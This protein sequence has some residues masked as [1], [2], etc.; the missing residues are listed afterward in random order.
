MPA[1]S[2]LTHLLIALAAFGLGWLV[3][4]STGSAPSP[5]D[6][7]GASGS[8][9]ASQ[10]ASI[11]TIEDPLERTAA[12]SAFFEN[13]D[14]SAAL[15]LSEMLAER[16]PDLIIDELTE[17]L[18]GAWWARENPV[19]A[20]QNPLDPAWSERHPYMRNVFREWVRTDPAEAALAVLTLGT[21]PRKGRLEASRVVVDEW[22]A[23]DPMPEPEPLIAVIKQLEP[24]ARD[25]A[26]T[27]LLESMIAERGVDRTLDFV[28][29]IPPDS[30]V[31]GSV[32]FEIQA[33]TGV[34]L[35]DHDV[36]RAIAWA[37]EYEDQPNA[38][39]IQKHIAYYWGL[40]QGAPAVEW[41]LDLPESPAKSAVIKRA[42]ISFSRK[43]R[44]EA[45]EWISARPPIPLMR[46]AFTAYL[47]KLAETEP[48][49]ALAHAER[50]EGDDFRHQMRA[51]V[52]EGWMT[53]DPDA[54]RAWLA[55]A[56]LPPELEHKVRKAR[57]GRRQPNS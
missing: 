29:A 4:Q 50:A 30:A 7:T 32:Q 6:Y 27:H 31:N 14:Q 16:D 2:V 43:H 40:K 22:L 38:A 21:G 24:M 12:L 34:V 56:G 13:T 25:G 28:R 1:R 10:L 44:D 5:R 35:L 36:D 8:N 33:R 9:P 26:I 42:W 3:A 19:A 41:A 49:K 51:A 52:A 54:A 11:L 45:R 57:P 48:E 53:S 46:G 20:F 23:L 47:K 17:S 37:R 55:S 15:V 39:G 18:F